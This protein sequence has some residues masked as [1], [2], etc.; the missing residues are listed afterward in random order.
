[1]YNM[2]RD[3]DIAAGLVPIWLVYWMDLINRAIVCLG[4]GQDIGY[5]RGN[6]RILISALFF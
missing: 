3:L 4:F 5:Y 1:M 6:M 2:P